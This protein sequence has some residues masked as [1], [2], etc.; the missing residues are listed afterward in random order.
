MRKGRIFRTIKRD[1]AL[2]IFLVIGIALVVN[3]IIFIP[4][5]HS[6]D[7]LKQSTRASSQSATTSP[8]NWTQYMWNPERSGY[9]SRET[10][11]NPSSAS[12]LKIHWKYAVKG[13]I[14]TEPVVVN[15]M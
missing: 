1:Y 15:G 11:I 9:N 4:L 2:H 14:N 8:V 6:T 13:S 7:A 12:H 5:N 10:I 3:A